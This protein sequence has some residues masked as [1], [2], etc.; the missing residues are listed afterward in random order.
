MTIIIS[1]EICRNENWIKV[2]IRSLLD[3][4]ELSYA[5]AYGIL[6]STTK[7]QQNPRWRNAK[8]PPTLSN[9]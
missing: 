2:L 1:M 7:R 4:S 5:T 8:A 3:P 9:R 6:N